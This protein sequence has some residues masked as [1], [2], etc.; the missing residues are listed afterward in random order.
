[1]VYYIALIVQNTGWNPLRPLFQVA[2]DL[3]QSANLQ[4]PDFWASVVQASILIVLLTAVGM[5]G[6]IVLFTRS[7]LTPASQG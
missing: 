2:R 4:T 1:M 3:V 7:D 5:V 6:L